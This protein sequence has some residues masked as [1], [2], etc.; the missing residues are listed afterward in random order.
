MPSGGAHEG[1]I[2]DST[3]LEP[4]TEM[5]TQLPPRLDIIIVNWNT[6]E[7]LRECIDSIARARDGVVIQRIVV[8][9]NAS[10]DDSLT[11]AADGLAVFELVPN[12]VNRG[13]AAAC[14]QG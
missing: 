3:R 2:E 4:R 1:L 13:F 12:D 11:L 6:G 10:S 8:V 7:A 5:V 9:D 14:N